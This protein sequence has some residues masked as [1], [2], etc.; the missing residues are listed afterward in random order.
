MIGAA[1]RRDA[2]ELIAEARA[3]GARLAP[4]CEALGPSAR[5]VQRWTQA[6]A[7]RADRRPLA[8]RPRP[9]NALTPEEEPAILAA[10]HRPA[11]ARLPPEQ[12]VA[13]LLDQGPVDQPLVLHADNG[14]PFK[15]AT[16]F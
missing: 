12:I 8:E 1:D 6:G 15:G 2:V 14:S 5:T 11:F 7:L 9:A 3:C 10:C 4:A 16:L 13:R